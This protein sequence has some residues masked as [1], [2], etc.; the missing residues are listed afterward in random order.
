MLLEKIAVSKGKS[1]F[2]TREYKFFR[3]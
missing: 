3:G 1:I 2:F